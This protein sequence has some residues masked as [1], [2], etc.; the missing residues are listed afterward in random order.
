MSDTKTECTKKIEYALDGLRQFQEMPGTES[1]KMGF[2]LAV[3]AL[4]DCMEAMAAM[5]DLMEEMD[6]EI[7]RIWTKKN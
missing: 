5:V 7:D 6:E 2:T 3:M 1:V 4:K